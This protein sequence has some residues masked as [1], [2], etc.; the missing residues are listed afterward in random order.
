M[1][2]LV[3]CDKCG[4][5]V[6]APKEDYMVEEDEII[7]QRCVLGNKTKLPT[8]ISIE[9]SIRSSI[10]EIGKTLRDLF[11]EGVYNND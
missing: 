1:I 11:K 8:Y 5:V 2:L 6:Y 3:Q 9:K 4:R 10:K 7:C